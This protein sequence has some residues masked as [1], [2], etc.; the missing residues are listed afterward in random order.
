LLGSKIDTS[1]E[2]LSASDVLVTLR[3]IQPLG[4]GPLSRLKVFQ[5]IF[6]MDKYLKVLP[7]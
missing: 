6:L 1:H 4:M 7:I 3:S 2:R 5:K